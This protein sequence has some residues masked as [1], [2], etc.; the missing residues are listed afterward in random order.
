MQG[1]PRSLQG[2]QTS[3]GCPGD[4][5]AARVLASGE[6]GSWEAPLG[7]EAVGLLIRKKIPSTDPRR[8]Q[9]QAQQRH[10][11]LD[12]FLPMCIPLCCLH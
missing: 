7:Q 4:V 1:R 2:P 10:P 11:V 12:V 6:P 5:V 8:T 3:R 9:A